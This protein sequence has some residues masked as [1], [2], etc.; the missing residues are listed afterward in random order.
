[1]D[2]LNRRQALAL[3]ATAGAAAL[4]PTHVAPA[5]DQDRWA[6]ERE[7][8]RDSGMTDAEADC[9]VK[10]AQAAGAM[11]ALPKLHVMD[12][13]EIADAVHVLQWKLLSRPTYRRYL[14]ISKGRK[15]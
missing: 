7:K 15:P 8:V 10:V 13:Q 12:E 14:E 11:L 4:L 9:W 6:V 3:G 5:Q 1:M 2:A